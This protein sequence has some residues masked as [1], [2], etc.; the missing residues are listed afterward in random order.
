MGRSMVES[1]RYALQPAGLPPDRLCG[2][3]KSPGDRRLGGYAATG[4]TTDDKQ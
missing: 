2:R 1:F 3:R 4:A